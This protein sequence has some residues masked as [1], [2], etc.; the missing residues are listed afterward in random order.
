MAKGFVCQFTSK[1]FTDVLKSN[2]I[3][4]SMDGKGHWVD[5]VFVERLW[6]S[7]WPL[8]PTGRHL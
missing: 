2:D 6:R 3:A 8:K 5:N 1:E 7:G 4:I